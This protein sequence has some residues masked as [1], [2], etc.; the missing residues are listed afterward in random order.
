MS[1]LEEFIVSITS[2]S[3]NALK[4]GVIRT[5]TTFYREHHYVYL[6]TW[7]HIV[8]DVGSKENV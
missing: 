3:A 6:L 7:A 1:N 8:E 4:A 2:A 5:G